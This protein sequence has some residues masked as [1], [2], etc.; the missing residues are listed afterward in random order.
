MSDSWLDDEI[1]L[2]EAE[3]EQETQNSLVKNTAGLGT[4]VM[5]E[6]RRMAAAT[7]TMVRDF[8]KKFDTYV[9]K[10]LLYALFGKAYAMR[11]LDVGSSGRLLALQRV[12]D[13]K[14]CPIIS[15]ALNV[16]ADRGTNITVGIYKGTF[17][18]I[19]DS[20]VD[21][22][23][24]FS[25]GEK[26][27]RMRDAFKDL[28]VHVM[29]TFVSNPHENDLNFVYGKG[30]CVIGDAGMPYEH[31]C[32][33]ALGMILKRLWINAPFVLREIR[34]EIE[35]AVAKVRPE[36]VREK[37]K[38][39][40]DADRRAD[41]IVDRTLWVM[42]GPNSSQ[43]RQ[44]LTFGM[45]RP[46]D[47]GEWTCI[48]LAVCCD[49]M[50]KIMSRANEDTVEQAREV[51]ADATRGMTPLQLQ[52]LIRHR[53]DSALATVGDDQRAASL[54]TMVYERL[55]NVSENDVHAA[56]LNIGLLLPQ[57]AAVLANRN[58]IQIMAS[59]KIDASL[60]AIYGPCVMEYA[61]TDAILHK[62]PNEQGCIAQIVSF[63][64]DLWGISE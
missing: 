17:Q 59:L 31:G 27:D 6:S 24:D 60:S 13:G 1:E 33:N 45:Q 30:R 43:W 9:K 23:H 29:L 44:V 51:V 50:D 62:I 7:Q 47:A 34:T 26:D 5:M 52:N 16:V 18:A 8:N 32:I 57:Q 11:K 35:K 4:D 22:C 55:L 38:W 37:L 3:L 46:S 42:N 39:T 49:T 21:G 12:S 53:L 58:I 56:L 15:M 10:E 28:P 36:Y 2:L 48:R 54:R 19:Q 64:S 41:G 14:L 25:D 20:F 63:V 40:V 61:R